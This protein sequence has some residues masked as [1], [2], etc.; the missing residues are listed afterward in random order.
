MKQFRIE[1]T[2]DG[3]DYREFAV[4]SANLHLNSLCPDEAMRVAATIIFGSAS[5][6]GSPFEHA[7]DHVDDAL[8]VEEVSPGYWT[9]FARDGRFCSQMNDGECLFFLFHWCLD[10]PL[11]WGGLVTYEEEVRKFRWLKASHIALLEVAP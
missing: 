11:P 10:M 4:H 6:P 8:S 5:F 3:C 1:K 9:V 7:D 2:R